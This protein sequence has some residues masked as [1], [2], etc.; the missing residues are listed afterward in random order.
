MKTAEQRT[1][2]RQY[3]GSYMGRWRV[4]SYISYNEKRPGRGRSPFLAV[5]NVAAYPL[6]TSV[7]I[8]Y[9]SIWHSKG[10]N[11]SYKTSKIE[12]FIN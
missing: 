8:M 4:G 7:P 5:P 10:L 12:I 9:N 1:I 6:T 2:I 3:S 11:Q